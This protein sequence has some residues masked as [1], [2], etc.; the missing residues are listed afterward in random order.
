MAGG[1][2]AVIYLLFKARHLRLCRLKR[3]TKSLRLCLRNLGYQCRIGSSALLGEA[4]LAVLMFVGNRVFMHYLGDYGVAA[5][6]IS[7]YYIPFVFM[8]GNATAQS[9]QPIISYNFGAGLYDRV[10][11]TE[12][13]ALAVAVACGLTATLLFSVY[14]HVAV[15]LFMNHEN[16]AALIATNGF[17]YF[18][19]GFV[20]FVVN[21]TAIGYFQSVE[22]I[23]PATIFALLRG[24]GLYSWY[25]S[26]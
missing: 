4:T 23:M 12:R 9:A 6:G 21:I 3:S 1:L 15:S 26:L 2:T 11:T 18:A 10:V 13:I 22:K 5:F 24:A 25:L 7:C 20:C 14:P 8:A 19:A 17:P 16:A